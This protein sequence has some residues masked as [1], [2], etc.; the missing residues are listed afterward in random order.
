MDLHE[1]QRSHQ[2]E[3]KWR[4]LYFDHKERAD[5]AEAELKQIIAGLWQSIETAPRDGKVEDVLLKCQHNGHDVVYL[6]H[7]AHGDGDGFMPSFGPAWFR[8]NGYCFVEIE[9][10][11]T[12]WMPMPGSSK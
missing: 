10:A 2:Q 6:G 1:Y 5:R 8:W 4:Q 12:H 7:W 11:P 3:E 9:P